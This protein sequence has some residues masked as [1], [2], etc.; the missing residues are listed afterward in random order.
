M[1]APGDRTEEV[2]YEQ[3][4]ERLKPERVE[5][6]LAMRRAVRRVEVLDLAAELG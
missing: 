6:G 2:P 1:E 5:T 3:V 4:V